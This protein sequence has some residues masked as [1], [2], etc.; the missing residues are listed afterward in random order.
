VVE[1]DRPSADL[2]T[3]LLED[4]GLAAV[5]AASGERALSILRERAPA[6]VVLDIRLPG[7][8]GWEVLARIKGSPELA[9]VPVIVVSIVDER[10]R[11]FALGAYDYLVK[12]VRR[13]ALSTA[14]R[15]AGLLPETGA[16]RVWVVDADADSRRHVVGELEAAGWSVLSSVTVPEALQQA[17]TWHP[18]AVLIDLMSTAND[19]FDA[20]RVLR[21]DPR[22]AA[23]PIVAVTP[24]GGDAPSWRHLA[25]QITIAARSGEATVTDLMAL[26]ERAV[27]IYPARGERT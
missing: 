5:T 25:D 10:G 7:I 8:D 4:Q 21:G 20:V 6:A 18:D 14:L 11:G 12:P 26:L 9:H 22:L 24:T 13:E 15:R 16:R 27:T 2:M 3:I 17:R 1:D 19:G 23:V